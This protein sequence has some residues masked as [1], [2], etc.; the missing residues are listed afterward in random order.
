MQYIYILHVSIEYLLYY[1]NAFFFKL[2]W[3]WLVEIQ[4]HS[5]H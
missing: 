2:E 5:L 1:Q 4:G 3:V